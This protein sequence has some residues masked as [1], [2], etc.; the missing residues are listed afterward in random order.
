M[1]F[2]EIIGQQAT[3]DRLIE[4]AKEGRVSHTQLF[5]GPPGN[6]KLALALAYAQYLNC[7]N[8]SETDSCGHCPACIKT[9]KLIHPD[10][11]FFYPTTT[12]KKIKKDPESQ[13]FSDEWRT[14]VLDG[15]G[16]VALNKW[17]E[18]LGVENKQGTIFARDATEMIKRLNLKAYEGKYK[19]VLIWM[20][21]KMHV[22]AANKLLKL[23]EEPPQQTLFI[24]IS[25][26][27]EQLLATI[28]SRAFQ[29]KIPRIDDQSIASA[30]AQKYNLRLADAN[31]YALMA[32]GNWI[33][34]CR[35]VENGD[36][37]KEHFY[38]TQRWMRLCFK[39]NIPELI[40]FCA[41]I[42]TIGREKQ[43][44][45]LAFSLQL[46][47]NSLLTNNGL[48]TWVRLTGEEAGFTGKFAPYVHHR[49]LLELTKLMEEGIRQIERNASPQILFMDI[50]LK[51]S[52]LLSLKP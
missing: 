23:L 1:K 6:G 46:F 3:I 39:N 7:H 32:H 44:T 16:Y 18:H 27:S 34:A 35:L 26:Q 50:S 37:D 51:V 21:E 15:N 22:S 41:E 52:K 10:L 5:F 36:E 19:I 31:P 2:S 43:K 4:S 17:Y 42:A 48:Q 38:T 28:R 13:L 20:V 29:L 14:F 47:H 45:F 40:D 24:L 25:E 11:H 9:A 30:L 12:T 8:P 33:E 49:N